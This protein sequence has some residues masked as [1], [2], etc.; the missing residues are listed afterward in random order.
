MTVGDGREEK[1]AVGGNIGNK[2][3]GDWVKGG[4]EGG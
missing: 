3:V 4:R 2:R 1:E